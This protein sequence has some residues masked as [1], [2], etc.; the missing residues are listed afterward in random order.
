MPCLSGV[1]IVV[2][3]AIGL[4]THLID[5]II[6]KDGTLY[7]LASQAFLQGNF[8]SGLDAYKWP[9]YPLTVACVAWITGMSAEASALLFNAL[10]RGL[11]GIAFLLIV[12]RLGGSYRQILLA[13]LVYLFFPGL[14]ELQS[15]IIRD[16]AFLACFLWMI[17]FFVDTLREP[18]PARFALFIVSGLLATAYRIEGIVYLAGLLLYYLFQ[19]NQSIFSRKIQSVFVLVAASVIIYA[20]LMWFVDG[21]ITRMWQVIVSKFSGNTTGFDEYAAKWRPVF[22]NLP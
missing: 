13:M 9:F 15:M 1:T 5:P 18:A 10:M 4:W 17:V 22:G 8:A 20:A 11:G 19:C 3:L 16:I 2:S 14:N 7:V 6:N 12:K 21:Q